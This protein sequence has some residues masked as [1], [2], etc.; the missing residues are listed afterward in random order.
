MSL[1]LWGGAECSIV[2]VGD[3]WRDSLRRSGHDERIEDL[4][5]F[6]Q[7]GIRAFRQPVLWERV[8]PAGLDHADWSWV[9][10]RLER[11]RSL[12]IRPIAGLL[13]HG[14]GP[15]GTDLL[16]PE[17]AAKLAAYARAV[18]RR[19]PWIDAYTP[20][21]EPLTTARFSALYGH[22]Y[23]H[24]KSTSKFLQAL[25]NQCHGTAL[26]MRAVREV[27]P[28][29]R[30]FQT[31]DFTYVTSTPELAHQASYENE[32][33]WL[34]IDLLCGRVTPAHPFHRAFVA[35]GVSEA[36]MRDLVCQPAT[37]DV[38]GLN[39][40]VTSERFLDARIAGYPPALV[41]GNGRDVYADVETIRVS[42]TGILGHGAALMQAWKR[43]GLPLALT[44]VH[45]GCTPEQQLRW[46][47]D[48]WV[49]CVEASAEGADV[50]ALTPWALLGSHDWTSLLVEE[51]G[52]YEPG[53]FDVRT[54]PPRPTALAAMIAALARTG[55]YDH[56]ALDGSGWWQ[57]P[58]RIR[59]PAYHLPPTAAPAFR[60]VPT[61]APSWSQ[62]KREVVIV[63]ASPVSRA[64]FA[65]CKRRD[66]A[67]RAVA[68][69][70]TRPDLLGGWAVVHMGR[71]PSAPPGSIDER[72]HDVW[73]AVGTEDR[74]TRVEAPALSRLVVRAGMPFSVDDDTSFVA[75]CALA[76]REGRRFPVREDQSA[77]VV[78]LPDLVDAVLDL[79]VD[80]AEGTWTVEHSDM[81][82]RADLARAV[83]GACA[84]PVTALWPIRATLPS[85]TTCSGPVQGSR[86]LLLRPVA[87]A[88]ADYARAT[89]TTARNQRDERVGRIALG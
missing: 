67:C 12:G 51:R 24:A 70:P 19:Y 71:P 9:D 60:A 69:E 22:W 7:L 62:T 87:R 1:E 73:L 77:N 34:S 85:R 37:P 11:L 15:Q 78:Y 83:A 75:R 26:A 10:A 39:Y 30:L 53:S 54:D 44:E 80:R 82:S 59:H 31:E 14:S 88:L 48:A 49:G 28:A 38:L 56:P 2:R 65:A 17:F 16:D 18:A 23:P 84:L 36:L 8:A 33:R 63:G 25:A 57:R 43:Y 5:L 50:R 13:H 20:V 46:L 66:L 41:G 79:L 27:N 64:L 47:R 68:G 58:E 29:A 61:R 35:S 3:T 76:L 6:A 55:A 21:N 32:R 86:Q 42:S 81:L 4:D 45:L 40:Y 52:D 74:E 89:E 72:R